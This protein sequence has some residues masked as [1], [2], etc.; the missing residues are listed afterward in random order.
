MRSLSEST[1]QAM[2]SPGRTLRYEAT[3]KPL[4]ASVFF[5]DR[6]AVQRYERIN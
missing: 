5:F 1:L 4:R 3:E 6:A 2:V